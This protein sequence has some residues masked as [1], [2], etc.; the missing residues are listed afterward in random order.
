MQNNNEYHKFLKSQVDLIYIKEISKLEDEYDVYINNEIDDIIA[1]EYKGKHAIVIFNYN[2]ITDIT[3]HIYD[4]IKKV[5]KDYTIL[6][7][8]INKIKDQL[9]FSQ[10]F[11]VSFFIVEK[12]MYKENSGKYDEIFRN[13]IDKTNLIRNK[14]KLLRKLNFKYNVEINNIYDGITSMKFENIYNKFIKNLIKHKKEVNFKLGFGRI[15][16]NTKNVLTGKKIM[17]VVSSNRE[18]D[19]YELSN[20]VDLNINEDKVNYVRN[21]IVESNILGIAVLSIKSQDKFKKYLDILIK[22]NFLVI[23]MNSNANKKEN[24]KNYIELNSY[25]LINKSL[26]GIKVL[27]IVDESFNKNNIM[28]LNS[29]IVISDTEIDD[30]SEDSLLT[31]ILSDQSKLSIFANLDN[32][33]S[34]KVLTSTFLNFEGTNYYSGGAE[35]YLIDL[36]EICS[37]LGYKLRIYQKGNYEFMRYYEDIEVVGLSNNMK[38]FDYN[39]AIDVKNNYDKISNGMT[40]LNIYSALMECMGNPIKPSIGISH[41]VA[42]D[43]KYNDF[44]DGIT[45]WNNNKWIIDSAKACDKV[46]SV[47]TNTPNWFQTIDF[48]LGNNMSVIPNYVDIEQ[49]YPVKRGET[50]KIILT[51]PR[52]VYEAR[53]MYL[54][55]DIIDDVLEKYNNIEVHFVGKGFKEDIDKVKEKVAKWGERIKLYNL[56]PNKMHEMYKYTDISVIPTLYS[57]GTSLSCL[58]AMSSGNAV[59]STR[60]GGLTDLV[61]NNYNGKLIEPNSKS[62]YNAICEF[63]D[64]PEIMEKCKRNAVEVAKEFNKNAWKNK[65]KEVIKDMIGNDLPYMESIKYKLLKI[66]LPDDYKV[67]DIS[68]IVLK[69]LKENY[70]IYIV[71]KNNINKKSSFGRLQYVSTEQELYRKADYVIAYDSVK[72]DIHENVDEYLNL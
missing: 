18:N 48:E 24:I 37:E 66:Y 59:I 1:S 50:D 60:I 58:E 32:R 67:N 21:L 8:S 68:K 49:F 54:L 31:N 38:D 56:P 72:S 45:F 39:D 42:W 26:S 44:K 25:E 17:K 22:M 51:Y 20:K 27:Y 71:T 70:V 12:N 13:G 43:S 15:I 69:Y 14:I 65:W 64:N 2:C 47:D 28:D 34:I 7:I 10:A 9:E 36:H 46:V 40:K 55:L 16:S 4:N 11:I 41:G 35:R 33:N 61:I 63:M 3:E 62:L 52:R 19:D 5:R 30:I 29:S 57:E 23:N 53:G 6:D